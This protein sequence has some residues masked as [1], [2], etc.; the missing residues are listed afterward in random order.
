MLQWYR[1]DQ[2]SLGI[3]KEGRRKEQVGKANHFWIKISW[4]KIEFPVKPALLFGEGALCQAY[5]KP[6]ILGG[7]L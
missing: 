6:G 1:K 5:K 2:K 3:W 7:S 4:V